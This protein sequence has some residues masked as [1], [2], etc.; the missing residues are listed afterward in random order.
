VAIRAPHGPRQ[1][2]AN[3][4]RIPSRLAFKVKRIFSKY[5]P[6]QY[7]ALIESPCPERKRLLQAYIQAAQAFSDISIAYLAA[8]SC[9]ERGKFLANA[10][11]AKTLVDIAQTAIDVHS[12]E[13]GCGANPT[14]G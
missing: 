13:H 4:I 5:I 7:G 14:R 2:W 11:N 3:Q 1:S 8:R 9:Q 6:K 12:A 10:L